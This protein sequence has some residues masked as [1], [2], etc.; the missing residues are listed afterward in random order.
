MFDQVIIGISAPGAG[1]D[2]IAFGATLVASGSI[3]LV[4]AAGNDAWRATPGTANERVDVR[5][6]LARLRNASEAI[7][8]EVLISPERSL[9]RALDH[10]V[11]DLAADLV[12]V[13]PAVL[14]DSDGRVHDAELRSILHGSCTVAVVRHAEKARR[15]P[16][17][18][19]VAYDDS[20]EAGV[21]LAFAEQLALHVG[22]T[23]QLVHAIEGP[24]VLTGYGL[25]TPTVL[26]DVRLA[27]QRRLDDAA[28]ALHVP[29]VSAAPVGAPSVVL[30]D[31]SE[32]VDLLICGTHSR[33]R[34]GQFAFGSTSDWLARHAACPLMVVPRSVKLPGLGARTVPSASHLTGS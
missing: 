4:A 12:V 6:E 20:G 10:A 34:I 15:R 24:S 27:A 31:V 16:R 28:A 9:P 30:A 3:T 18:I 5:A 23:L 1:A 2:A 22:A 33:G 13:E 32:Q 11:T 14:T 7:D 29:A 8:A 19:G 17:V 25:G 26:D 21:A